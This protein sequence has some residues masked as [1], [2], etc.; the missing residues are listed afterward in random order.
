MPALRRFVVSVCLCGGAVWS[1]ACSEPGTDGPGARG[2]GS[3][4]VDSAAAAR[5]IRGMLRSSARAWNAGDLEGFL[6]DYSTDPG[7]TFVSGSGVIRG[8]E[9]VRERYLR[10]YWSPGS[11]RDSLRFEELRVRPLEGDHALAHGRYV[12]YRPRSAGSDSIRGT[13]RFTLVLQR[14][15]GRW[16][17]IHDHSSAAPQ[18]GG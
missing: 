9:A 6:D 1:G 13:G 8:I 16:S 12:L 7:L 3:E 4:G 14:R 17:I 18:G 11:R 10:T 15:D 5:Q 2:T